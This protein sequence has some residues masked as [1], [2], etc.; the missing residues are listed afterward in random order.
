MS[1]FDFLNSKVEDE[2][3]EAQLN[4]VLKFPFPES[5]KNQISNKTPIDKLKNGSGEFGRDPNN[6]IPVNGPTGEIK[7]LN[8]LRSKN[9]KPF[10][11]HRIGSI[12]PKNFDYPID[13]YELVSKDGE[14]WAVLFFDIYWP[15]RSTL[16][17]KG[18]N[19]SEFDP[20][21][22]TNIIFSYGISSYDINFPYTIPEILEQTRG[23][24]GKKIA[25]D[26]IENIGDRDL[27]PPQDHK[28]MIFVIENRIMAEGN[29]NTPR[30]IR[31]QFDN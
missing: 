17:P 5:I 10:I 4:E 27:N 28:M 13:A 6:P 2:S 12:V 1:F 16:Y 9:N 31:Y 11:Y 26:I 24:V 23:A 21:Y 3:E 30:K 29:D 25:Q 20:T 15:K 7:Y 19:I 22:S 8:R 14:E 18:L